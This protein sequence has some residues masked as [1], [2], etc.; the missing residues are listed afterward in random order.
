MSPNRRRF[1]NYESFCGLVGKL[2]FNGQLTAHSRKCQN[3]IDCMPW[4]HFFLRV[5]AKDYRKNISYIS[6]NAALASGKTIILE[7]LRQGAQIKRETRV[8]EKFNQS[9]QSH[10]S[11]AIVNQF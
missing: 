4:K 8:K 5:S 1:S 6:N 2:A 10:I 11:I 3:P 9:R 7:K